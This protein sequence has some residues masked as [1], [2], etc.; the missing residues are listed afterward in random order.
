MVYLKNNSKTQCYLKCNI[1]HLYPVILVSQEKAYVMMSPERK[2]MMVF[3]SS[4]E[5]G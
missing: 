4:Q 5:I 2:K 3:F 1:A